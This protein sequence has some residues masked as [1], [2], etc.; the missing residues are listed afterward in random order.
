MSSELPSQPKNT[1]PDGSTRMQTPP[2]SRDMPT[3]IFSLNDTPPIY[4]TPVSAAKTTDT[5]VSLLAFQAP[6]NFQDRFE[7]KKCLGHGGY[8]TVYLVWDRH[9]Q[10]H[11]ALK[12]ANVEKSK[13][14]Q[15][16]VET[17]F[18]EAHQLRLLDHPGV[19]R[20]YEPDVTDD[21]YVYFLMDYMEGDT[22]KSKLDKHGPFNE[23]NAVKTVLEIAKI[24]VYVHQKGIVHRDLKPAN[25]LFDHQG[26]IHVADFGL[27]LHDA[28]FG[29]G[30]DSCGTLTYMS[31]EQ[32][33][34]KA[35]IVNGTADIYSLGVILY[36]LLLG[37]HP[38]RSSNSEQLRREIVD[39][40]PRPIRQLNPNLP[41][42]LEGIVSKAMAK[43][44]QDRYQSA[45]DFVDALEEYIN[46]PKIDPQSQAP[47]KS[48]SRL[49]SSLV[50]ILV[51]FG[52]GYIVYQSQTPEQV[53]AVEESIQ[54]TSNKFGPELTVYISDAANAEPHRLSQNELPFNAS[55][56]IAYIET[57]LTQ[58]GIVYLFWIDVASKSP[59]H[60]TALLDVDG[61]PN[62]LAT[63]VR[64]SNIE[65]VSEGSQQVLLACVSKVPKSREEIKSFLTELEK[66]KSELGTENIDSALWAKFCFD[67]KDSDPTKERKERGAS[68][69]KPKFVILKENEATIKKHFQ[70]YY[71]LILKAE[72]QANKK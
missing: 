66:S 70:D 20:V 36:E 43:S 53:V 56:K 3:E 68:Q 44:P 60:E 22:L 50:M 62:Q 64:A 41:K 10:Q 31:P 16:T 13:N 42:P 39:A 17:F 63:T 9:D 28:Q 47:A 29:T 2:D 21:G 65:F 71:G 37:A 52:I 27:A 54:P 35:D 30:P 67:D 26:N 1:K 15:H 34:G 23:K 8:G 12:L 4:E 61:K 24:L 59:W 14:K 5:L 40:Q 57:T 25:L 49:L 7:I 19:V 69:K 58:P 18:K 55:S 38:Y 51:V 6:R 48:G 33:N 32:L 45:Q 46:G 72:W 11:Y